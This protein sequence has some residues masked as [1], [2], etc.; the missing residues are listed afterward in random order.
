MFG[1]QLEHDNEEYFR[2]R[3]DGIDAA[4][5]GTEAAR[6]PFHI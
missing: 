2:K 1:Q 4:V 5:G 6:S 3:E